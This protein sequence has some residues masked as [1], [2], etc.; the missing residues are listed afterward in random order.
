MAWGENN[1]SN[2]HPSYDIKPTRHIAVGHVG[3]STRALITD[4]VIRAERAGCRTNLHASAS[5]THPAAN[6]VV[7]VGRNMADYTR[8][9]RDYLSGRT[10]VNYIEN[11]NR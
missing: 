1:P 5:R 4:R 2:N 7:P 6:W 11:Q 10:Q 3:R 8:N 9:D